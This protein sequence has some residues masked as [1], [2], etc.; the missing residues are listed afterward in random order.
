[1]RSRY[2]AV[3]TVLLVGVLV[4]YALLGLHMRP[5][6]DD[7]CTAYWAREE[8]VVGGML[9]WYNDWTGNYTNFF[10][11][12]AVGQLAPI[13]VA[14][15]PAL[16]LLLSVGVVYA[17]FRE[18]RL[19]FNFSYPPQVT[20]VLSLGFSAAFVYGMYTPNTFLWLSSNIPNY[21][22]VLLFVGYA[23]Y[24]SWIVRNEQELSRAVYWLHVILSMFL[25]FLIPGLSPLFAGYQLAALVLG[26]LAF[27]VFARGRWRQRLLL[28]VGLGLL[29]AL[30]GFALNMVAPG[31]GARLDRHE[32]VGRV[33]SA[34]LTSIAYDT[35]TNGLLYLGR[36]NGWLAAIF[37]FFTT[38]LLRFWS[39]APGEKDQLRP[40]LRFSRLL[41]LLWIVL[42]V[43]FA[44]YLWLQTSN[45]TTVMG[46]YSLSYF[47]ILVLNGALIGLGGL[48]FLLQGRVERWINNRPSVWVLVNSAVFPILVIAGLALSLTDVTPR[49]MRYF[50]AVWVLLFV[51][52]NFYLL[53][54]VE[55]RS[56]DLVLGLISGVAYIL[57]ITTLPI[58]MFG[59]GFIELRHLVTNVFTV[60]AVSV[61]MGHFTATAL[62]VW[63]V[64]SAPDPGW[65]QRA[66]GVL[67]ILTIGFAVG[68]L[69]YNLAV[70]PNFQRFTQ[71]WHERDA[72]LR[73]QVEQ[74]ITSLEYDVYGKY[75]TVEPGLLNHNQPFRIPLGVLCVDAYYR[76]IPPE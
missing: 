53:R 57:V 26:L 40:V 76:D 72:I 42:Q 20:W 23:A 28:V 56:W 14:F 75:Y 60:L 8:G 45:A 13:G 74:G 38:G 30:L 1:M 7:F 4:T 41:T 22:P 66:T 2:V 67:Q 21:L 15:V 44:P 11:K 18:M 73:E 52:A 5:V 50:G 62:K 37:V 55:H 3:L 61:F 25:S 6:F 12:S 35:I 71:S 17:F 59:R 24:S 16:L 33:S 43:G 29:A 58:V 27:G 36:E 51:G 39:F 47:A 65:V 31:T 49:G 70:L 68:A 48:F 54:L 32:T 9:H 63:V 46:R 19:A 34:G 64:R 69:A 10:I